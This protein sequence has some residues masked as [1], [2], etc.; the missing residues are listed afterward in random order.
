[1]NK[2]L[3]RIWEAPQKA[4][5]HIVKW[6]FK[7]EPLDMTDMNGESVHFY[8]WG[9][10]GGMSLSNYI[11]LPRKHFDKPIEEVMASKWHRDYMAHEYGHTIQSHKLGPLYLLVIAL[12]S[13]IWAGCFERYRIKHNI[14]YYS[15]YTEA[16]ADK[17]GRV[18]R[19]D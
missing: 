14:S 19:E 2:W 18:K 4:L 3:S 16:S 5:A 7:S 11:F 9:H 8:F 15:F 1:M 6:V 17:L 13:L 10:G 12:P